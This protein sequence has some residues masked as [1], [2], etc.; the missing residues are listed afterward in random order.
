[1]I[2]MTLRKGSSDPRSHQVVASHENYVTSIHMFQEILFCD[3]A[4]LVEFGL[5]AQKGSI[6]DFR[7]QNALVHRVFVFLDKLGPVFFAK[8]STFFNEG[9]KF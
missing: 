7:P 3:R 5:F 4:K 8:L 2:I 9:K 1:M 6:G